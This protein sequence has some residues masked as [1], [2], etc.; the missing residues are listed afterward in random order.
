MA[1]RRG[2]SRRRG[3]LTVLILVGGAALLILAGNLLRGPG[4]RRQVPARPAV[5]PAH[6]GA[7]HSH[8]ISEEEK[9]ELDRILERAA[10]E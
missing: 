5:A 7:E 2:R 8:E 10:P 1:R 6:P 9:R 4:G 3:I